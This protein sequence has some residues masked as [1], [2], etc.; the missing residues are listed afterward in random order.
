MNLL[1]RFHYA[2]SKSEDGIKDY[3]VF[4]DEGDILLH[5]NWQR[6]FV[7]ILNNDLIKL[8]KEKNVQFVLTS[9]SPFVASDLSKAHILYL[10]EKKNPIKEVETFS[11]NIYSLLS[12]S[13]YLESPLGAFSEELLNDLINFLDTGK[14]GKIKNLLEAQ[15]IIEN[16]G[17]PMIKNELQKK[18]IRSES[19]DKKQLEELVNYLSK[20][21]NNA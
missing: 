12:N 9:H 3:I 1:S 7:S 16:I 5:P 15:K 13:F 2:L 11:Q 20:K 10:N 21:L 19:G 17:E 14:S 4:I 18:L 8:F 6:R